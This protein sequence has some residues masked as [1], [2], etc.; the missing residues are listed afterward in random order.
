M[1]GSSQGESIRSTI[2]REIKHNGHSHWGQAGIGLGAQTD[3]LSRCAVLGPR[4][5]RC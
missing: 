2:Q 1:I 5:K 3:K 4:C